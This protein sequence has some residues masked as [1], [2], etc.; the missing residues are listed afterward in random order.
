[1][2]DNDGVD[3]S[4]GETLFFP[5]NLQGTTYDFCY[6][7]MKRPGVSNPNSSSR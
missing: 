2:T 4:S 1:M 3:D 7:A 6:Q 5:V